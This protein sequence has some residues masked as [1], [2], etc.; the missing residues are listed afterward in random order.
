MYGWP[1]VIA[2]YQLYISCNGASIREISEAVQDVNR[3]IQGCMKKKE[4]DVDY[5]SLLG[6][7]LPL[8]PDY[9]H[10]FESITS[11]SSKSMLSVMLLSEYSENTINT[12]KR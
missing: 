10:L 12:Q 11:S 2:S 6:S 8:L 3:L 5:T 7:R 4:W 9:E 1:T